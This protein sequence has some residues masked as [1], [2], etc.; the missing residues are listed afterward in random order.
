MMQILQKWEVRVLR[1]TD[2]EPILFYIHDN[3]IQNVLR[4]VSELDFGEVELCDIRK[5]KQSTDTQT[6]ASWNH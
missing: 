5:V 1:G 4:K 3:H 2:K 6:V